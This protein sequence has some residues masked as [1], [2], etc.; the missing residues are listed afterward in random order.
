MQI[1]PARLV[2]KPEVWR[3]KPAEIAF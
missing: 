2:D 1:F 3:H